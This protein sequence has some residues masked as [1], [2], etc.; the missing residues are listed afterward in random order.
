MLGLCSP[1]AAQNNDPAVTPPAINVYSVNNKSFIARVTPT[2]GWQQISSEGAWKIVKFNRPTVPVWVSADYVDVRDDNAVVRVT[3]LNARTQASLKSSVINKLPMGYVAKVQARRNG[4]MQIAAPVE[5]TFAISPPVLASKPAA[6]PGKPEWNLQQANDSKA[7]DASQSPEATP[8][9]TLPVEN[10]LVA[11]SS[12]APVVKGLPLAAE[13]LHTISPGDTIS[14]MVFGESDLS[15]SNVRVPQSGAVSFPLIGTTDVAGKTTQQVEDIVR[16]ALAGGYINNPK[17]SVT[18]DSYRPIFIRG[19]VQ[20]TG[21]FPYTEG[22]TVAQALAVAGGTKNSAQ[23]DGV[24]ILRNGKTVQQGLT[25]DSQARIYSGDII[26]IAEEVGVSDEAS[27]YVYLHGEVKSPGEY[28][29]RRGL[30]VE[31]AIVLAGGFS[32]RASK[33]RISVSRMVEGELKPEKL[34]KV[35]LYLAVEPGDIIDVGASFF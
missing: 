24:S 35:K 15:I 4:Y 17:L 22:L 31:K 28:L 13:K 11:P 1:V 12:S 5:W 30:T 14:L 18:I 33:K 25:V 20:S 2:D 32:L 16:A 7:P 23:N 9:D 3:R 10:V 34:R 8:T 26:T 29:F 19:A 21:A 6:N 27:F